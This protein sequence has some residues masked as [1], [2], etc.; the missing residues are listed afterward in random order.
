MLFKPKK[1]NFFPLFLFINTPP[2]AVSDKSVS[3]PIIA[4][5][6]DTQYAA[7]GWF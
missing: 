2:M 6:I 7:V 3:K 4:P 5:I 1:S